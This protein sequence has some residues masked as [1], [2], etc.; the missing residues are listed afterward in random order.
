MTASR[1]DRAARVERVRAVSKRPRLRGRSRR[2]IQ[3]KRPRP[4]LDT[5]TTRHGRLIASLNAVHLG[6]SRCDDGAPELLAVSGSTRDNAT[7][8]DAVRR[9]AKGNRA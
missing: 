8:C 7:P 1:I 6:A 3:R 5:P 2:A 9:G 4:Y